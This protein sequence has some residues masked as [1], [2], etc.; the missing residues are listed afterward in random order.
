L[1]HQLRARGYHV[2]VRLPPMEDTDWN[3]VLTTEG[4]PSLDFTV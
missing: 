3:D 4:G 2:E 1:A